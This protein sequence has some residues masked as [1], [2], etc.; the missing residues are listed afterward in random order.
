MRK[1]PLPRLRRR[2]QNT[3]TDRR[4]INRQKGTTTMRLLAIERELPQPIHLNRT[5]LLRTEAAAIW[6]LQKRGIIR[7]L[8]LTKSGRRTILMLECDS[9]VQ[10]RELIA[11]LPRVRAGL[12]DFTVLELCTHDG[13]EQLFGTKAAS[14]TPARMEEPP[15]Y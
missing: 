3:A 1:I 12:L 8:W 5:D 6:D 7:D 9:F 2:E 10:A 11:N 4:L 14:A 13:C 15:E